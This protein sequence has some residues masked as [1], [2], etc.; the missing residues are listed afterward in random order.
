MSDELTR[1]MALASAGVVGVGALAACSS[2]GDSDGDGDDG[3][4][5]KAPSG[6]KTLGKSSDVPVGGG[7]IYSAQQVVVTQPSKGK[8]E[9]FSSICTHQGCPLSAIAGGTI[10]CNCHGSKFKLADGSVAHGPAT[11]PLPKKT[12]T[13]DKSGNLTL[14]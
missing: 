8:F 4:Q 6:S 10:N 12:V 11:K 1:R 5:K 3:A 9:A 7:K 13:V 2:G 14:G